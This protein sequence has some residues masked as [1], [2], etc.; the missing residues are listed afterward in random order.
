MQREKVG[1]EA[2]QPKSA[3]RKCVSTQLIKKGKKI[4]NKITAFVPSDGGLTFIEENDDVLVAKF[5]H[6]GPAVGDIPGACF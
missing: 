5:G 2:Q 3:T 4:R 6:K 1:I